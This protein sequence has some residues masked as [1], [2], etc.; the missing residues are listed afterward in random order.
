MKISIYA[1]KKSA[2]SQL[3]KLN[4]RA[5][6]RQSKTFNSKTTEKCGNGG[7]LDHIVRL[8][9]VRFFVV[10]LVE[11][12]LFVIDDHLKIGDELMN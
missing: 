11:S 10:G 7:G 3:R 5:N 2:N 1:C 8:I 12:A 9:F 6:K 4:D